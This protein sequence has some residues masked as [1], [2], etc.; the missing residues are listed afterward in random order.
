MRAGATSRLQLTRY[1]TFMP[2]RTK[3]RVLFVCIGNACRSPMAE[4]VAR[5]DA[6]DVIEPASAGLYP[7]GRIAELTIEILVANGYSVDGLSSKP[8]LRGAVRESRLIVNLSGAPIDYLFSWRRPTSAMA[9]NSK[10]G[11]LQILM[12]KTRPLIREFSKRSK[13]ECGSLPAAYEPKTDRPRFSSTESHCAAIKPAFRRKITSKRFGKCWRSSRYPS[14]RGW[15][16][17]SPS[18]RQRLQRP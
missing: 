13:R 5:R 8:I 16:K 12:A 4:A 17:N 10:T 9:S 1:N 14:A 11:R 3:S 7:L 15:P 6:G 2:P 18:R